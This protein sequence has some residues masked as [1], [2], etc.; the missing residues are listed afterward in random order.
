M[1]AR[2]RWGGVL[3]GLGFMLPGFGLMFLLSWLYLTLDLAATAFQAVFLG[4]QP[5]VI[6]LIV[7]ADGDYLSKV[8][9]YSG[10]AHAVYITNI[11]AGSS[12]RRRRPLFL[13]IFCTWVLTVRSLIFKA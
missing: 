9:P 11:R 2:G 1:L 8:A 13:K 7:R 6:A 3:A 10:S 4:I 5:A 12:P